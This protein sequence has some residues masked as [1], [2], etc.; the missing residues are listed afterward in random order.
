MTTDRP[1]LGIL[2]MLCFC[3]VIPV[4]DAIA[5]LLGDVIPL[6]QLLLARFG[7]QAVLMLPFVWLLGHALTMPRRVFGLT[8]IRSLL[9]LF[10][11]GFMFLSLQYLPLADAVAIAFV[12]PFISLLLGKF[13][14]GEEVGFRR[15]AACVVGFIGTLLIIQPSF[16]EVGAPALLPLLV[17]LSFALFMLVTRSVAKQVDPLSLQC[18]SG[19]VGTIVLGIAYI[20]LLP[21]ELSSAQLVVPDAGSGFLLLALGVIGTIAHLLMTWSLRFAPSTTVAPMQYLEIPVAALIGWLFFA[22]LPNGTAAIGVTITVLAGLYV[23]FREQ[24][25]SKKSPE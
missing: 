20:G 8:I 19:G 6:I 11:V 1:L 2:L 5:K 4:G 25:F 16:E 17:A 7:I 10:G 22:D 24:Q 12:M 3:A 13:F 18:V 21:F 23:I 9:H 14:L 15:L